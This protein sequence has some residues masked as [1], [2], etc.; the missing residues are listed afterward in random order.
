MRGER[1]SVASMLSVLLLCVLTTMFWDVTRADEPVYDIDIPAMHAGAALNRFAEQTGAV[2][3]FPYDLTRGRW[4]NRVRGRYTL[5]EGLE[6][7]LRGTGLSGGLSDKRVVN[8]SRVESA[9]RTG[10]EGA[11]LNRRESFRVTLSAFIASLFSVPA[12]AQDVSG[13]PAVEEVI[14]TASKR[15]ER[16]QDLPASI[17]ALGNEELRQRGAVSMEDYLRTVPGLSYIDRGVANNSV[18][19]R[20]LTADAQNYTDMGGTVGIY[21][22]DIPLAGLAVSGNNADVKLVDMARVEVLRGPQGTLFGDGALGGAVRNIPVAPNLQSFEGMVQ[23]G[24]SWTGENGGGNSE[25]Q[26]VINAPL[27]QDVFAVRAVGYNYSNSG[28]IENIAASDPGFSANAAALG[29]GSLAID[30]SE[31]GESTYEGGRVTALWQPAEQFTAALMFLTQNL[32]QEGLPEVQLGLDTYQQTRMH[33]PADYRGGTERLT[34]DIRVTNLELNYDLGWASLFSSSAYIEETG[35]LVRDIGAAFGN[36]LTPQSVELTS[37]AVIE[38]L[39]MTSQFQGP[40]QF[41]A[42]FYYND[43]DKRRYSDAFRLSTPR[44]ALDWRYH[45]SNAKQKALFGEVSYELTSQFKA[46]VGMRAFQYD[47]EFVTDNLVTPVPTRTVLQNKDKSGE[48]YKVNLTYQPSRDGLVYAQWSQGF[49]LG[50]PVAAPPASVCDVDDDGLIDGTNLSSR[51]RQLEPDSLDS[52]ELGA[53]ATLLDQR[54]S[55]SGAVYRNDWSGIPVV[56]VVQCGYGQFVNAGEAR[57]EGV[58]LEGTLRLADQWKISFGASYVDAAL[59]QD[60]PGVGS[61]GDR[62]PGSPRYNFNVGFHYAFDMMER[63]AF[64][65]ADYL[66]TGGFYNNLAATGIEIADYGLLNMRTGITFGSTSV[67]AFINNVTNEDALTWLDTVFAR[68][69]QRASRLRPRTLGLSVRYQF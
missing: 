12:S 37:R 16:I 19:M 30:Q 60:A 55:L 25:A 24:Y 23:A 15:S 54:L 2:M 5:V 46:T 39:R 21:L 42:G 57:T 51:E 47:Q 33:I 43:G 68:N 4:T 61:E 69:D 32:R 27:V 22:G 44:Q 17:S 29:F 48:T 58:E 56:L 36:V 8:I 59:T 31:V 38:E 7:L 53:K 41:L 18:V 65:R 64:L 67:E 11:V 3:L 62:L 20:G 52:Y 1:C 13:A 26:A 34:D 10:E 6:L 50:A 49:R 14:V 28:Y 63:P 45:T 40:L 35:L 9:Q 66:R